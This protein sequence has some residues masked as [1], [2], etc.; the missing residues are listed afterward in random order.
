VVREAHWVQQALAEIGLRVELVVQD[1]ATYFT[2][3]FA[4]KNYDMGYGLQTPML[5]ADEYLTGEWTSDGPRNWYG[6][7]DPQLDRM[8]S[9]QRGELDRAARERQLH[10][11]QRYI[12]ENVSNPVPLY[13][14]NGLSIY[15]SYLHDVWPHPD[16]GTRHQAR[17]WLGPE[18]PGRD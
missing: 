3:S 13:V 17:I 15:Q 5:S 14:Y 6:I 18:A 10:D 4:G 2:E 7:A 9:E 8:I 16:Y 11:I 12:I 1:Y